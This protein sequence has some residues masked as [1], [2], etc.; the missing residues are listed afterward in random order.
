MDCQH[1]EDYQHTEDCQHTDCFWYEECNIKDMAQ[2]CA[3]NN[4]YF[5]LEKKEEPE[6]ESI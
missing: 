2:N 1:T 6:K 5:D 4:D 3:V